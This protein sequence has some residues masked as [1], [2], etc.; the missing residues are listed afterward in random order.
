MPFACANTN[1]ISAKTEIDISNLINTNVELSKADKEL[2]QSYNTLI[3]YL[4]PNEIQALKEE[5]R[6]WLKERSSIFSESKDL[7]IIQTFYKTRNQVLKNKLNA[8]QEEL[9]KNKDKM[10][11]ALIDFNQT[12]KFLGKTISPKVIA[13][14]EIWISDRGT[15]PAQ[16]ATDIAAISNHGNRYFGDFKTVKYEGDSDKDWISMEKEDGGFVQYVWYGRL[17]NGLHIVQVRDNGGGT[18]TTLTL[19]AFRSTISQGLSE[20]PDKQIRPY[21][22]LLL[23]EVL[24]ENIPLYGNLVLKDNTVTSISDNQ[25]LWKITFPE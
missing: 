1:N 15:R 18:L 21:Y 3:K 25:I 17:K 20:S 6:T 12:F 23:E 4:T 8:L 22:R 7:T 2:N 14:F 24:Q 10:D 19:H 9:V 5:Q 13:E 11:L 16:I